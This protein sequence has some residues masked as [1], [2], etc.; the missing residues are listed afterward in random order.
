MPR[1]R[2]PQDADAK[3][4]EI[5]DAATDLFT[6]QGYEATSLKAIAGAAGV[7]ANTIYWYFPDKDALLIGVADRLVQAALTELSSLE[8]EPLAV[9]LQWVVGRL[10][11]H[12]Q[13][14]IAVH[15]RA[16][17]S[18]PVDVWHH[19]FHDLADEVLKEGFRQAGT[20]ESDLDARAQM[21][22]LVVEG[23]ITHVHEDDRTRAIL[24]MLIR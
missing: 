2:R 4:E 1:N 10:R 24:G 16:D 5:L 6:R 20:P 3:R 21:A 14:V 19:R 18:P 8:D 17:T 13:L 11:E 15:A 7:T 22:V 9:Q 12:H 23:L